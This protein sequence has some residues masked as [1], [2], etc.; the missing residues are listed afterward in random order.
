MES[1]RELYRG[2]PVIPGRPLLSRLTTKSSSVPSTCL[3]SFFKARPDV[4]GPTS[5]LFLPTL[6][7][8]ASVTFWLGLEAGSGIV[9]EVGT[10]S[11]GS[12]KPDENVN[13]NYCTSKNN[14]LQCADFLT[15]QKY[16]YT[17]EGTSQGIS[18]LRKNNKGN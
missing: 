14:S 10:G 11:K 7:R 16:C 12:N 8:M 1:Y 3:I 15:Q 17:I 4:E 6:D 9:Y 18:Q 2:K 13:R 5:S